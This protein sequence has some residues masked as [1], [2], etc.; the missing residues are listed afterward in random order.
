MYMKRSLDLSE[1][2]EL[3]ADITQDM[4][5]TLGMAMPSGGGEVNLDTGNNELGERTH[6][7]KA[8]QRAAEV[9]QP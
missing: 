1:S 4:Q 7:A 9:A 6:V 3:S 2:E 5:A 8:R